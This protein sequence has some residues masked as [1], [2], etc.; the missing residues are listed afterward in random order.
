VLELVIMAVKDLAHVRRGTHP[1]CSKDYF[2]EPKTTKIGFETRSSD[3]S[4]VVDEGFP[5]CVYSMFFDGAQL[6][7]L[8]DAFRQQ[9]L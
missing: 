5:G 2:L 9:V 7:E 1:L 3:K 8:C 4:Q 6:V